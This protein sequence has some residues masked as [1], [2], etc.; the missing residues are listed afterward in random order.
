[1]DDQCLEE[2]PSAGNVY[3]LLMLVGGPYLIFSVSVTT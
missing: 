2:P 3:G 1:M